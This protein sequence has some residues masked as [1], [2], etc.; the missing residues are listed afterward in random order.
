MANQVQTCLLTSQ[1]I[2][3]QSSAIPHRPFTVS[4]YSTFIYQS[5]TLSSTAQPF[6]WFS[7]F[8]HLWPEIWNFSPDHILQSQ[9]LFI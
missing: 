4:F 7:C 6:I 8:S 9:T 1:S 5:L 3:H 2:T